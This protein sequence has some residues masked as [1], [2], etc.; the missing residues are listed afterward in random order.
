MQLEAIPSAPDSV[1]QWATSLLWPTAEELR[2]GL[3]QELEA[4]GSGGDGPAESPFFVCNVRGD[5]DA[6]DS[7]LRGRRAANALLTS[8]EVRN[9]QRRVGQVRGLCLRASGQLAQRP[10]SISSCPS[11]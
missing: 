3:Q 2:A 1:E 5:S 8:V 9:R 7:L 4:G 11:A 10:A 6:C